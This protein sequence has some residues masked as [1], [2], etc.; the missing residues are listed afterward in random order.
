MLVVERAPEKK[1]LFARAQAPRAGQKRLSE[2]YFASQ[3]RVI[4]QTKLKEEC[5]TS[6]DRKMSY[7]KDAPEKHL[8]VQ[9]DETLQSRL[10]PAEEFP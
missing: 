2:N 4:G 7:P 8:P 3:Q 1:A 5:V 10:G 9:A 6:T